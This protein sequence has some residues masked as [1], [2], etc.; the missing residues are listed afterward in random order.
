MLVVCGLWDYMWVIER[1]S[2]VSFIAPE[3]DWCLPGDHESLTM[4]EY[5][6]HNQPGCFSVILRDVSP[7]FVYGAFL[8]LIA[9]D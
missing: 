4:Y 7:L 3:I 5:N 6:L 1:P 8:K 9:R 2:A